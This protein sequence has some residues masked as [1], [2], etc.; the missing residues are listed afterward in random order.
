MPE[1]I[2]DQPETLYVPT[3]TYIPIF[4]R[5]SAS[6]PC[7]YCKFEVGQN[8]HQAIFENCC[9]TS[10]HQNCVSRY[11][12]K[13]GARCTECSTSF[14]ETRLLTSSENR[15][16]GSEMSLDSKT[17]F[18]LYYAHGHTASRCKHCGDVVSQQ[19]FTLFH[20]CCGGCCH[21]DCLKP[22][23]GANGAMCITC[24]FPVGITTAAFHSLED[25]F[26]GC[27][28]AYLSPDDGD[29]PICHE[30]LCN[31][32]LE[33]HPPH[34]FHRR[35]LEKWV[36]ENDRD[37]PTCPLCR[38]EFVHDFRLGMKDWVILDGIRIAERPRRDHFLQIIQA[39]HYPV[40]PNLQDLTQIYQEAAPAV[41]SMYRTVILMG[42][43]VRGADVQKIEQ[44]NEAVL[45]WNRVHISGNHNIGLFD[46][47][48]LKEC[49]SANASPP[50]IDPWDARERLHQY[51]VDQR[52]LLATPDL[53]QLFDFFDPHM[54]EQYRRR[55]FAS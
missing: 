1:V 55:K 3:T 20:D 46:I 38:K 23:I 21:K 15:Q 31:P 50:D 42:Q 29:C 6:K 2:Y 36:Y 45:S 39:D 13:N 19:R 40:A 7:I 35:C 12:R 33:P 11:I 5:S 51:F 27:H 54:Y 53:A 22:Y 37:F 48:R 14:G 24:S 4:S 18:V 8:E 34:R 16:A 10:C 32:I 30:P 17:S 26:P 9:G 52:I 41:E 49:L 47:E 25:V 44:V 43:G 28:D